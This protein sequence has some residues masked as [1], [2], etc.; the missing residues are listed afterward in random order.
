MCLFPWQRNDG[1]AYG[2]AYGGALGGRTNNPA[3]ALEL[4]QMPVTLPAAG[5]VVLGA[6]RSS[7]ELPLT[8]MNTIDQQQADGTWVQV[9]TQVTETPTPGGTHTVTVVNSIPLA[10]A[11]SSATPIATAV[12]I[13]AEHE[14]SKKG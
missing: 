14:Y 4:T 13:L 9:T 5:P 12:P 11:A 3:G 2:G 6:V 1:G 8:T 7:G 10:A